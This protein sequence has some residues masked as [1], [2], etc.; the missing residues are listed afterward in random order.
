MKSFL[1]MVTVMAFLSG[2]SKS[3]TQPASNTTIVYQFSAS[4]SSTYTITY[5]D[6]NNNPVTTSFTGTTWSKT[7]STN[8]AMGFKWAWFT[9]TTKTLNSIA[10]SESI[11]V[12]N[13]SADQQNYTFDQLYSGIAFH[14]VVFN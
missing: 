8:Q 13:K 9:I 1:L 10:T 6:A 2:C 5:T 7:I 12:N 11:L 3:N 14:V 4:N